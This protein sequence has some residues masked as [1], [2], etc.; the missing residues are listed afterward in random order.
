MISICGDSTESFPEKMY[1]CL[2][3]TKGE[4]RM[5]R[6]AICTLF[7]LWLLLMLPVTA[8]AETGGNLWVRLEVGE[9][10]V[11]NGAFTL[12]RVG[13]AISDGYRICEDYGGG[14]V[15]GE[16][17][18]S[19]HLA[20]WL[21]GMGEKE[22]TEMLMDV[23]GNAVFSGL[24]DGLYLLVQS[25]R[26]DGFYPIQPMLLTIPR[27]AGR[28]ISL[29]LEPLPMVAEAPPTGQD[30]TPYVGGIGLIISLTGLVL[31]TGGKRHW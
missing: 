26:T 3:I 31:C 18:L 5:M 7:A 9:L 4:K 27:E 14:F 24:E 1:T 17:A 21:A 15:R 2:I 19:P 8:D 12:Y 10:P 11:T 6:K 20:Q 29:Q 30:P 16:D 22:G 25:E 23:D 28:D 13:T